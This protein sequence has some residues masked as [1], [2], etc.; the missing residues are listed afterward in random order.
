MAALGCAEAALWIACAAGGLLSGEAGWEEAA[1]GALV[2]L[3][4]VRAAGSSSGSCARA[5]GLVNRGPRR[6]A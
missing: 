6:R 4:W 1:T 3:W 5:R 2:G